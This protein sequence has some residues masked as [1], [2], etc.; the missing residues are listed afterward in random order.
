M[1][2][3]TLAKQTARI[4]KA[5]KPP[6][7]RAPLDPLEAHRVGLLNGRDELAERSVIYPEQTPR[8]EEPDRLLANT[9]DLIQ[10]ANKRQP[11]PAFVIAD[12]LPE[13]CVTLLAAHGD[14]GKSQIG[15]YVMICIAAGLP[16]FGMPA[17]PP[18]RA[19][20]YSCEDGLPV[21][22]W[23]VQQ[24]CAALGIPPVTLDGWLFVINAG[25]LEDPELFVEK[26][27]TVGRLTR[28]YEELR[29]LMA[30]H[31][32]DV[33]AIDNA[34]DTFAANEINRA[35]VRAFVRSLQHLLP[36][37][38]RGAVLLL[39]HV[40]RT[41]SASNASGQQYSGTTAW[42]N[43]V[44]SRL[45]L[46]RGK[47]GTDNA[48]TDED[49]PPSAPYV[50]KRAKGNYAAPDR[51]GLQFHWSEVHGV[52]LPDETSEAAVQSDDQV[53][54]DQ[55]KVLAAFAEAHT[56]GQRIAPGVTANNNAAKVFRDMGVQLPPR[57]QTMSGLS[58]VLRV[59]QQRELLVVERYTDEQRKK[60]ERW[61][62]TE[63]GYAELEQ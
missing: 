27:A 32:I 55:R 20:F 41:A 46:T 49:A 14:G 37:P 43:S 36:V 16:V 2:H 7:S 47:P 4:D 56:T 53:V 42:H 45:E 25:A 23:R 63:S 18:R 50:L 13:G 60:R 40:N 17:R 48:G 21:L 39:A 62:L 15:L 12:W 26:Q 3:D 24:Y 51:I 52:I 5:G 28:T 57:L 38:D 11:P 8:P 34:S 22:N 19:L 61:T 54:D 6:R 10:L 30:K 33:V 59:L 9:L 44:R 31:S 35:A 58:R 29:A 1:N